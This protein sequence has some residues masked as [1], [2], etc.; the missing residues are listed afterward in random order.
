MS[1]LTNSILGIT[2]LIKNIF[3]RLTAGPSFF[4]EKKRSKKNNTQQTHTL[5]IP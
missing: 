5:K 1:Y 3:R 4:F 2:T